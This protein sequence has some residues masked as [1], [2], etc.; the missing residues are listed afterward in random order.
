MMTFQHNK[1]K[2][3]HQ[4]FNINGRLFFANLLTTFK[5][6]FETGK[7]IF[8]NDNFC[9]C[10]VKGQSVMEYFIILIFISVI[11][12]AAITLSG[13][14]KSY[15]NT[16][17]D[18]GGAVFNK[19]R[20]RMTMTGCYVG[21]GGHTRAGYSFDDESLVPA[22]TCASWYNNYGG[23]VSCLDILEWF[24]GTSFTLTSG[25]VN[26]S[27][28]LTPPGQEPRRIILTITGNSACVAASPA[29]EPGPL[30]QSEDAQSQIN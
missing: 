16:I 3:K 10:G 19:A 4:P 9:T 29:P 26:Q 5:N 28:T 7:G 11:I 14:G 12:G 6:L 21:L 1:K 8:K 27:Y 13:P 17:R 18:Q 25:S 30:P 23:T 20:A 2:E 22:A 24:P 15:L